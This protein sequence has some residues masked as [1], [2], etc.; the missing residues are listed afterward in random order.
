MATKPTRHIPYLDAV[1]LH[2]ELMELAGEIRYGVA[3][4]DLVASALARPQQAAFYENADIIRQAATLCSGFQLN[5]C[6]IRHPRN[7]VFSCPPS[8]NAK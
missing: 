6:S 7:L 2:F 1:L 3:N 4:R 8:G 5:S